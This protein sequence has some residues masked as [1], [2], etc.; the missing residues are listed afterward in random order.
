M[1]LVAGRAPRQ[2]PKLRY[3]PTSGVSAPKTRLACF[4]SSHRAF[5]NAGRRA[6]VVQPAPSAS[7]Y[8]QNLPDSFLKQPAPGIKKVL[9]VGSGGLA[10][11]QAGE[12]DYSGKAP[13]PPPPHQL[14]FLVKR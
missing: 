5:H 8:L 4:P 9:V 10:I 13:P 6:A 14:G 3:G 11:G 12:F 1:F 2:L 7:S